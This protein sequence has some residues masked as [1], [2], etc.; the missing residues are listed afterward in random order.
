MFLSFSSQEERRAYG[1]SDFVEIGFCTL[2]AGTKP[3]DAVRL[4]NIHSWQDS[5]LYV[6][7]D[8]AFY[9]EYCAVFT[10]GYYANGK[11]GTMDLT[12]INYYPAAML[13]GI[14]AKIRA[15]APMDSATLCAWLERARE[16]NG[17]YIFGL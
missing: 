7:D 15:L 9:E 11:T 2:P 1:G 10:G 6:A 3:A 14:I 5:S 4:E 8:H 12:G 13:E 17:F 16:Y